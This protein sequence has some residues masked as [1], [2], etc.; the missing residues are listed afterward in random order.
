MRKRFEVRM[1]YTRQSHPRTVIGREPSC[2]CVIG[3]VVAS[4]SQKARLQMS[5]SA[6][7]APDR[8]NQMP[9]GQY[10]ARC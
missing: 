3:A 8:E 9:P 5:P 2:G 6:M 1:A 7:T 10:V 4:G